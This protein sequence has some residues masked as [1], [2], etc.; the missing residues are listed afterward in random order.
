MSDLRAYVGQIAVTVTSGSASHSKPDHDRASCTN[1]IDESS[2]AA[3]TAS[4]KVHAARSISTTV[5]VTSMPEEAASPGH[6][7]QSRCS[8]SG[9]GGLQ[10]GV[11]RPA[12]KCRTTTDQLL[13]CV[14]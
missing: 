2:M 12:A 7:R 8:K 10:L 11:D 13:T 1:D 14:W 4:A 5:A 9:K 3:C 6:T